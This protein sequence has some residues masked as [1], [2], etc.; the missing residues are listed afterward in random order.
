LRAGAIAGLVTFAVFVLAASLFTL[1]QGEGPLPTPRPF[2]LAAA[3]GLLT[4]SVTS[5]RRRS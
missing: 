5:A 1:A 2:A 3:L 4:A